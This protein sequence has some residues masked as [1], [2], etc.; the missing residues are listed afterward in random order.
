D[1]PRPLA[2]HR[3]AL[4]VRALQVDAA[5]V[6]V[7]RR[8]EILVRH[9]VA[10]DMPARATLA[11]GARPRGLVPLRPLPQGEVERILLRARGRGRLDHDVLE[12]LVRQDAE[13]VLRL[14]RPEV[15]L[16]V[17]GIRVASIDEAGDQGGDLWDMLAHL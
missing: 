8:S 17:D 10:L 16:A 6:D 7:E 4:V 11:P 15:H 3:L 9:R 13:R 12:L 2:D 5:P 14:P 1:A